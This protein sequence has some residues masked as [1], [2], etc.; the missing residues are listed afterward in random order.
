M[1]KAMEYS[2]PLTISHREANEMVAPFFANDLAVTL[3]P[4]YQ[5][6]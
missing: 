3:E 1:L 5:V 2:S 4:L 6:V